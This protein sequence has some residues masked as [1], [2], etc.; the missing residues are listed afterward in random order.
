VAEDGGDSSV[1]YHWEQIE[2]PAVAIAD[3][4]RP[5]IDVL[6]PSGVERIVFQ[7]VIARSDL[8]RLVRVTVPIESGPGAS[9]PKP[10]G[11]V[12]ADAGDD[13]V[14]LVGY[15]VTLNGSRSNPA[16]GRGARWIQVAGPAIT[17]AEQKGAFYSF[18]PTAPGLLK[19]ILVVAGDAEAS[20]PD[21]VNVLV[22]TPPAGG[23]FAAPASSTRP[24]QGSAA[25]IS[26]D[27]PAQVLAAR[28]PQLADGARVASDVADVLEAV[29]DRSG[30][31]ESFAMFESELGRRLD[32]VVPS[33][34]AERGLW[35]QGV[36][37]PLAAYTADEML[38]VGL[39]LRKPGTL[40]QT[41]TPAQRER[42]QKHLLGLA[43]SFR[44]AT[45]V[46]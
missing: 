11:K 4:T 9:R 25:G 6:L 31:Y 32:T 18:I 34:P 5:A 13:Q 2:G 23:P 28:L 1:R 21:E 36:F 14:G 46:R 16:D 45:K 20:E 39:D 12:T 33:T 17:K 7:L 24:S 30:V 10:A 26:P 35:S 37:Q 3:R 19:F 42:L 43:R 22:G 40:Q 38:S 15:R 27:R 8:I 29:A 41:L 44:A